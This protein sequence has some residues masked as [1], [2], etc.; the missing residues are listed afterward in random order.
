MLL[1]MVKHVFKLIKSHMILCDILTQDLIG[2]IEYAYHQCISSLLEAHL[3]RTPGLNM[4]GL[5]QFQV[6]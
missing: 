2:L 3:Q 5:E 1:M 6:G 4:L